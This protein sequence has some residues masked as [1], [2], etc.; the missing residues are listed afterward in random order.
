MADNISDM[1]IGN[2]IE[3]QSRNSIDENKYYGTIMAFLNYDIGKQYLDIEAYHNAVLLNHSGIGNKED[4]HYFLIRISSQE[5]TICFAKEWILEASFNIVE[6]LGILTLNINDVEE[7]DTNI[8]RG[9]LRDHGYTST[10]IVD[11]K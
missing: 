8:I 10:T 2:V 1:E 9:L 3:F 5:L 4:M 6:N 11:F 7:A